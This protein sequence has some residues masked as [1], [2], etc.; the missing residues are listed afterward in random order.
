MKDA[1]DG[2]E[3]KE[4]RRRHAPATKANSCGAVG[5]R[6]TVNGLPVSQFLT[7]G[8]VTK[9]VNEIIVYTF[10]REEAVTAL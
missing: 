3:T 7:G 1:R 10:L 5:R 2:A 8:V 9:I 6:F 4:V